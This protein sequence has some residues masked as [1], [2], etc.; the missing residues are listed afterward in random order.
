MESAGHGVGRIGPGVGR[1]HAVLFAGRGEACVHGSGTR[2]STSR[3]ACR[4]N[5]P[6][7]RES[8]VKAQ[9][10]ARA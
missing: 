1:D 4:V 2:I 3:P 6:G 5:P 9:A 8:P 10:E 7:R